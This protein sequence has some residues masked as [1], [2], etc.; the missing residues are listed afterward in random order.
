MK[1]QRQ[2]TYKG[3]LISNPNS[4]YKPIK[5]YKNSINKPKQPQYKQSKHHTN[6]IYDYIIY[7]LNKSQFKKF[8]QI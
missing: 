8:S 6:T 1:I 7:E 2:P 3:A 4:Q 5:R